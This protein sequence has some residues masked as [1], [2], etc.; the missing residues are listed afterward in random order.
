[1]LTSSIEE[2]VY[3]HMDTIYRF[4]FRMVRNENDASDITQEVFIRAW[5]KADSFDETKSSVRT[6]IYTIAYRI[7]IDHIRKKQKS[8]EVFEQEFEDDITIDDVY[9]DTSPLPDELFERQEIK[10]EIQ[11]ALD[12]LKIE[13]QHILSL[14][15]ES[16]M[17]FMEIS[18]IVAKPLNTTKSTYRRAIQK[19]TKILAPKNN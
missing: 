9:S 12:T 1:M 18:E 10:E 6:W 17:T 3:T 5:K 7:T 8:K 16:N 13:E 19:L 15:H 14:Y 11:K 4:V 2:L